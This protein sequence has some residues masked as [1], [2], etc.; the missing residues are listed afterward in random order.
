MPSAKRRGHFTPVDKSYFYKEHVVGLGDGRPNGSVFC[1]GS[2][3]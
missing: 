3:S 1:P 2:L